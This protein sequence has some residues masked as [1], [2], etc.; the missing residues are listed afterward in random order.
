MDARVRLHKAVE[1]AQARLVVLRPAA[2]RSLQWCQ[3]AWAAAVRLMMRAPGVSL[4]RRVPALWNR[5]F[6]DARLIL[7]R[8]G[9]LQYFQ[10]SARLQ[11]GAVRS[12][13]SCAATLVVTFVALTGNNVRV[14]MRTAQLEREQAETLRTLAELDESRTTPATPESARTMEMPVAANAMDDRAQART[15]AG[16]GLFMFGLS[17]SGQRTPLAARSGSDGRRA[18]VMPTGQVRIQARA[19]GARGDAASGDREGS[20]GIRRSGGASASACQP[21]TAWDGC[22]GNAAAAC[23]MHHGQCPADAPVVS[24]PS[25]P[26]GTCMP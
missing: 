17:E 26:A 8:E 13:M 23:A 24:L 11:R 7:E 9:H 25:V 2:V 18:A 21:K 16:N 14:A 20:A 5:E 1:A 4:A 22:T 12:T 3:P 10:I 19:G 15:I 6:H